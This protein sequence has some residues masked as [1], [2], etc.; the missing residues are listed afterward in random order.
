MRPKEQ[1]SFHF[2]P[3]REFRREPCIAWIADIVKSRQL[4]GRDRARL[5]DQF[6]GL[7]TELNKKYSRHIL[8]EFVI[9]LGDEFQGLLQSGISIPDLMWDIEMQFPERQIRIGIGF[10]ILHTPVPK[11][12]LSVDGPALH[13]ARAAVTKAKEELSL[14]GVFNGFGRLDPVLNGIARILWFHRSMWT[15]RQREI[16]GLIRERR[17][18]SEAAKRLRVSRQAVSKQILS[19]GLKPYL[20]CEEAWRVMLEDHVDPMIVGGG[21]T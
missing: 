19:G 9:T 1:A 3:S 14:G 2:M 15:K 16:F 10:G 11:L 21:K 6:Q 13:N 20:E 12:T 17:T 18:Q 7:V 4:Q 5:Q 8:A